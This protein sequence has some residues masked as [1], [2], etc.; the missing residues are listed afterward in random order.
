MF[1]VSA[2]VADITE[3]LKSMQMYVQSFVTFFAQ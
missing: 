3:A 1:L 2:T